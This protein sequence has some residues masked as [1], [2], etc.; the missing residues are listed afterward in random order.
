MRLCRNRGSCGTTLPVAPLCRHSRRIG[1]CPGRAV[2]P[3]GEYPAWLSQDPLIM[4]FVQTCIGYP[5]RLFQELL[6][7]GLGLRMWV[8]VYFVSGGAMQVVVLPHLF[9]K[10]VP[11]SFETG[12]SGYNTAGHGMGDFVLLWAGVPVVAFHG[13]LV[14]NSMCL[15]G[16]CRSIDSQRRFIRQFH[17]PMGPWD[18]EPLRQ[19]A[20]REFHVPMGPTS[21]RRM[22][23]SKQPA[24]PC[25]HGANRPCRWGSAGS[26]GNSMCPWGQS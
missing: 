19:A 26:S 22:R 9:L 20:E 6:W 17:V 14:G 11:Y 12:V 10:A 3:L 23:P 1:G 13:S 24:I 15:Q 2:R 25:A 5:N 16:Q 18:V 4:M 7:A 8:M 21:I